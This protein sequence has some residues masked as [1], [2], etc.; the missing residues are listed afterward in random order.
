MSVG[1]QDKYYLNIAKASFKSSH[2]KKLF[3][4]F[5]FLLHA[6][7]TQMLQD[8]LCFCSV[9]PLRIWK[10][11]TVFAKAHGQMASTI[12]G[13]DSSWNCRKGTISAVFWLFPLM[14]SAAS[15][16]LLMTFFLNWWGSSMSTGL[17]PISSP[18]CYSSVYALLFILRIVLCCQPG[19]NFIIGWHSCLSCNLARSSNHGTEELK[20]QWQYRCRQTAFAQYW[21]VV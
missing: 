19:W 9:F 2:Q 12:L 15:C 7:L 11:F 4:L 17:C 21:R 18:P 6:S 3:H 5:G 1:F 13:L 8:L 10:K 16:Y 14:L 20:Y